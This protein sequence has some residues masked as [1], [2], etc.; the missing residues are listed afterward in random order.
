MLSDPCHATLIPGFN[1]T[2]EGILSRLKTTYSFPASA[3][4]SGYVLWC[5]T[6]VGGSDHAN[7]LVEY[8]N[9]ASLPTN[10]T[11]AE[12]LGSGGS[13]GIFIDVGATTFVQSNTVSDFRVVS[14]CIRVT[15]T[16]AMQSS[17]GIIGYI[18]NLPVDTLLLGQA[19]LNECAS[20]DDFL[21]LCSNVKR[22]GVETHESRYRPSGASLNTFKQDVSG[23]YTPGNPGST[24]T[25]MTAESKRFAPVFHG[26]AFKGIS[27]DDLNIEFIQNIEWRPET[28]AGF[29][30]VIPRQMKPE[31]FKRTVTGWLD[32][33]YPGW[34]TAMAHSAGRM[35]LRAATT[36][37]TGVSPAMLQHYEL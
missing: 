6:Y 17:A 35:A 28:R 29:V 1:G 16:G 32:K 10:N 30:S 18:E 11:V 12:P 25:I 27:M 31:G 26:F 5:P 34:A 7:C 14:A 4:T 22:M 13:S 24:R 2:D 36:A 23:V 19:S 3:A 9:D 15:Y 20:P 33:N 21:A 37:F 8:S